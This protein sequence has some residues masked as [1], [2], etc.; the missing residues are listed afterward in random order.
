MAKIEWRVYDTTI[1]KL[2]VCMIKPDTGDSFANFADGINAVKSYFPANGEVEDY[3]PANILPYIKSY[4]S[5]SNSHKFTENTIDVTNEMIDPY[6]RRTYI[7]GSNSTTVFRLGYFIGGNT[8]NFYINYLYLPPNETS[9]LYGIY[10]NSDAV[11]NIVFNMLFPIIILFKWGTSSSYN[12]VNLGISPIKYDNN[13]WVFL[14]NINHNPGGYSYSQSLTTHNIISNGDSIVAQLW[15]NAVDP[16]V[17]SPYTPGS[18]T[19]GD[20]NSDAT[21]GTWTLTHTGEKTGHS[22]WNDLEASL[23]RMYALNKSQLATFSQSIWNPNV[24][25]GIIQHIGGVEKVIIGMY[26]Y[27]FAVEHE[28]AELSINFNWLPA[29]ADGIQA[30]GYLVKDEM[31][32]IDF[33]DISIPA[34]SGTF[35]DFQPF[36]SAHLFIPYIG[37]VPLKMNEIQSTKSGC[38]LNLKFNINVA[39]GDFCAMVTVKNKYDP[40]MNSYYDMTIGAYN[41]NIA[42]PLP[43][44]RQDMMDIY[45]AGATLLGATAGTVMGIKS[46]M[47]AQSSMEGAIHRFAEKTNEVNAINEFNS[48]GD[49]GLELQG[50]PKAPNIKEY[51]DTVNTGKRQAINSGSNA[52]SAVT[53]ANAPIDRSGILGGVIGRCYEQKPFILL[54]YPHQNVSNKQYLLG[55][56]TN[57][58]G[59]LSNGFEGYTEVREIRIKDSNATSSEIAEIEQIVR[60]GIII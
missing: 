57:I 1:G 12:W 48:W 53:Q 35:Y 14:P 25:E 5:S 23:F 18:T 9:S 26:S 47:I 6:Q 16:P 46:A 4:K 54:T 3:I 10:S 39:T 15:D 34:Y 27:P 52:I 58:E 45:K 17:P 28:S 19:E 42:R 55:Y 60:G 41:G 24:L 8:S 22:G 59:P 36:S 29:W 37:F 20:V 11:Y 43:I 33:G 21:D 51:K 56:S 49:F 13:K 50:L 7:I 2:P 30:K 44:S 32:Q 31:K 38:T 40:Q